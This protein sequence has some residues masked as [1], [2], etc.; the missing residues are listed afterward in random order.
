MNGVFVK[1][2]KGNYMKLGSCAKVLILAGYSVCSCSI[3]PR[4]SSLISYP[5]FN[6]RVLVAC[7]GFCYKS[8]GDVLRLFIQTPVNAYSP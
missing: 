4:M 7:F 6:S 8:K 5:S 3:L 1:K 2:M